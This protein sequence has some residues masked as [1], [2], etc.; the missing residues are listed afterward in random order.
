MCGDGG[1]LT[2]CAMQQLAQAQYI[3]IVQLQGGYAGWGAVRKHYLHLFKHT[4][5]YMSSGHC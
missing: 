5:V 2:E 3:N 4:M 1:P